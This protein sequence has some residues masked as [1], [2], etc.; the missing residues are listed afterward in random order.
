MELKLLI[1]GGAMKPGPAVAQSLGPAGVPM[2]DVIERVNEVTSVFRGMQVPV[3]II[4]DTA[5]KT[6]EVEVSTPPVSALLKKEAGAE[7]GSGSH[8]ELNVGN[9]SI[10]QI[11][12][13]AKQKEAGL[14][15]RDLKAA[16]KTVLGSALSLGLLVESK[17]PKEVIRMVEAGEFDKEIEAG[18]TETP[19]EKRKELDSFYSKLRASQ[20]RILKAKAAAAEAKK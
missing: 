9:L 8:K 11:I 13:V 1:E 4:V 7:K 10:E 16:V 6:F 15:C 20:D 5:K 18:A 2:N 12:S 19:E 17:N 3:T 14:L